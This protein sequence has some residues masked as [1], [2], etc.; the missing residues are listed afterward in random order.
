VRHSRARL[1]YELGSGSGS[2]YGDAY[3]DRC[4]IIIVNSF[5]FLF[6]NHWY[7]IDFLIYILVDLGDQILDMV[8]VGAPFQVKILMGC[9]AVVRIWVMV[10]VCSFVHCKIWLFFLTFVITCMFRESCLDFYVGLQAPMVEV[11]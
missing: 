3:A 4:L 5:F 8:A 6:C 7:Y 10:E 2:H 9:I 1:D 11:M